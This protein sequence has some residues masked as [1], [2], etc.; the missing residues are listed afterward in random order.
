MG[1]DD[2]FDRIT[3]LT[4]FVFLGVESALWTGRLSGSTYIVYEVFKDD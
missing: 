4:G 1:A 3:G 2:L